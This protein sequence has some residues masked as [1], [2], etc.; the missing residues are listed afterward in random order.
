MRSSA[1]KIFSIAGWPA[2]AALTFGRDI[3]GVSFQEE[4]KKEER[5]FFFFLQKK[6]EPSE[7]G[8][9]PC[10][11]VVSLRRRRS[12]KERRRKERKRRVEEELCAILP[13]ERFR[14]LSLLL[15]KAL[16]GKVPFVPLT[17]SEALALFV[18]LRH[19]VL[20]T[21]A[22][23]WRQ[24]SGVCARSYIRKGEWAI[25]T[26]GSDGI[27]KAY[28]KE[29]LASGM[30]VLLIARSKANLEVACKELNSENVDYHVADLSQAHVYKGI[31]E[32]ASLLRSARGRHSAPVALL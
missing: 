24:V 5:D 25:V 26:G 19:L 8:G 11:V 21:A 14:E 28:A 7:S 27:G 3:G 32:S 17:W 12:V 20:P 23:L 22:Y 31:G 6:E 18:V 9:R 10:L 30:K 1:P 13:M 29:L 4:D 15:M 2:N 16:G